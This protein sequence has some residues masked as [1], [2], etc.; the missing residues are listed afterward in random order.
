MFFLGVLL[1]VFLLWQNIA[2]TNLDSLPSQYSKLAVCERVIEDIHVSDRVIPVNDETLVISYLSRD[3]LSQGCEKLASFT[4]NTS[5]FEVISPQQEIIVTSESSWQGGAWI[6]KSKKTGVSQISITD[7]YLVYTM[8]VS[9]I[10][11]FFGFGLKYALL[12][13]ISTLLL[14]FGAIVVFLSVKQKDGKNH[15]ISNQ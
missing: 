8:G 1:Y 6:I 15:D 14:L 3:Y 4:L 9:V 5:D 11:S 10:P 12:Q 2:A 13:T 7:G